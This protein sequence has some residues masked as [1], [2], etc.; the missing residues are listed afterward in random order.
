MTFRRKKVAVIGSG[1][2]GATTAFI[3][4]QKELADI[5]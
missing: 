5:V 3:M 4:A 1:F 2:T